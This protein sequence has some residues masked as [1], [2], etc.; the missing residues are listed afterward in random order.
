MKKL[1]L[2]LLCIA[3]ILALPGCFCCRR[4]CEE[5]CMDYCEEYDDCNDNCDRGCSV[6][7][8]YYD[9]DKELV[10]YEEQQGYRRPMYR[11]RAQTHRNR[12]A[13]V[14]TAPKKV[15][16]HKPIHPAVIDGVQKRGGQIKY[17][18][19]R[20]ADQNR[21]MGIAAEEKAERKAIKRARNGKA[22]MPVAES[23]E[24]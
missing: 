1:L 11:N 2:G 22:A 13:E 10:G 9:D 17:L 6:H 5:P 12:P 7:D 4:T 14:V 21:E 15:T 20:F 18:D 8:D 23:M 3:S 19:N 24:E 16:Y